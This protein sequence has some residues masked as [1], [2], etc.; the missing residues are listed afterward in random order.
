MMRFLKDEVSTVRIVFRGLRIFVE[1]LARRHCR[2]KRSALE[3]INLF[4]AN[5][6][7]A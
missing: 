5:G 3:K 4:K 6:V 1:R 2:S 7:E